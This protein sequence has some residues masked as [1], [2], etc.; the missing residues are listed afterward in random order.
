MNKLN[1]IAF[2]LVFICTEFA[3]YSQGCSTC[4]AQIITSNKDDLSVGNGINIGILFLM[5]VPYIIL[6]FLF[7]KKIISVYN[8]L[9]RSK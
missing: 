5:V 4:R 7:R 8:Q 9:F 3:T 2:F 1:K 6:F